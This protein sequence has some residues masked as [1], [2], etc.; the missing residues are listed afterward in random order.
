MAAGRCLSNG[1]TASVAPD[2]FWSF[3]TIV[4]LGES[5]NRLACILASIPIFWPLVKEATDKV[6]KIYKIYV[7]Q[8]FVIHSTRVLPGEVIVEIGAYRAPHWAEQAD[9]ARAPSAE[10]SLDQQVDLP[11]WPETPQPTS[12]AEP[13]KRAVNEQRVGSD[14]NV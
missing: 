7:T 12:S 1:S 9:D 10:G 3:P 5:E 11:E 14:E 8:E 6:Q 4:L 13:E 2:P